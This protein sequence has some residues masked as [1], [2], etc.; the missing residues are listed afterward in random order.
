MSAPAPAR[1]D[2]LGV[3]VS[4]VRPGD[5]LGAIETWIAE[6]SRR[7]VCITGVH[8][9]VESRRDTGLRAIHNRADMVTPDGM[10]L[11][12]LARALGHAGI[13]RVYGPDLMRALTAISPE[14]GYR[15]FCYGG[16]PGTPERLADRL[17]T[18]HRG[19]QVV[20]TYS[21][22]FRDLTPEEDAAIVDEINRAAPDILWIG[23]STP[24]QERWMAAHRA[25]LDVPVIV[26]VGAAF[27][28]LAETKRQAPAWMGNSGL[29]WFFRLC[30][31]PRRLWRRYADIVPTFI[32]LSG[33][34]I[35]RRSVGRVAQPDA[36]PSRTTPS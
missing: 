24:K 12:W 1:A 34:A 5:A 9:I 29:E 32:V 23:L 31:E 10:P 36:T 20:G 14:R 26:G 25:L 7:Y 3:R 28:F 2:L 11:V 35:A 19:L 33:L 4:L 30:T 22:P 18:R 13:A 15:H 27:D 16:A 17:R 21:P 8:G 6:R